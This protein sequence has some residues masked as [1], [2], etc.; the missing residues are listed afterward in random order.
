M[1][2]LC[3]ILTLMQI[4]SAQDSPAALKDEIKILP[5]WNDELPSR[6]FAGHVNAGSATELGIHQ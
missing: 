2:K 3:L 5:G 1:F 4:S 6:H